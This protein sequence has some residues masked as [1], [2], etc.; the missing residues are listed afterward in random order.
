MQ[1]LGLDQGY[2]PI[3]GTRCTTNKVDFDCSTF[4]QDNR[5]DGYSNVAAESTGGEERRGGRTAGAGRGTCYAKEGNTAAAVVTNG[6]EQDGAA[7]AA[8]AAAATG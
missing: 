8:A 4:A 6:N 5:T 1:L 3:I 7:A 2:A